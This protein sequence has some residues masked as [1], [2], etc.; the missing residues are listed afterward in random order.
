MHLDYSI[1]YRA[2]PV[3]L[4][5][6]VVEGFFLLKEHKLDKKDMFSN[7]TLGLGALLVAVIINGVVVFSYTFLY[8]F[9]VFTISDKYWWAWV[10]CFFCDDFSFYL[11]HRLSHQV[12]FLWASHI[13]HHSSKKFTLSAGVRLPW[14]SIVTGSFLF[15]AWMPLIGIEPYMIILLKSINSSYQ[16]LLHTETIGKL[17]KWFEAAFN[18][19]SHH[20]VHHSSDIEYLDK[21]YAGI[22]IIWDKLFGTYKEETFKPKYGLTED[23]KSYNP[24]EVEFHEWKNLFSDVK[25]TDKLKDRIHYF[26]DSPGWRHDGS[27]KTTKQLQLTLRQKSANNYS[28]KN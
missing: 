12:R 8:Q 19:P 11:Y 18:T 1:F 14:T 3:L 17:P 20:R 27:T 2:L 4:V 24:I 26:L 9:R 16:F 22:L 21:N 15:W 23:I 28:L 25:K 7:I 10:I 13:V 5:L 6:I